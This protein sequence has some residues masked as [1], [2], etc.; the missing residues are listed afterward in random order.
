MNFDMGILSV[1]EIATILKHMDCCENDT[2]MNSD[3]KM[4]LLFL[5]TRY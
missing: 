1:A 3:L 2:R 4:T 5:V